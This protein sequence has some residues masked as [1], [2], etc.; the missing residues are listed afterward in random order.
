MPARTTKP[1]TPYHHGQLRAALLKAAVELLEEGGI[2]N[3]SLRECAR[4]AGVSHAAP[5]RHF[6]DKETLLEAI[7]E[8]GFEMLLQAGLSAMKGIEDPRQRADAYGVAYVRFAFE[9]PH[10]H[11]VMFAR[12]L[13][14]MPSNVGAAAFQLLVDT[15]AGVV[16]DEVDPTVAAIAAWTIP[17]GLSML[18]LDGRIPNKYLGSARDIDRLARRVYELW[19]GSLSH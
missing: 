11:R 1:A 2:S 18:V 17:H 6:A 3:L 10:H 12:P 7:A 15:V 8:E 9:H 13:K 4:R 16:G 5:Y 19:R 14:Q